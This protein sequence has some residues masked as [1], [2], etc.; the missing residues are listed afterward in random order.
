MVKT[1]VDKEHVVVTLGWGLGQGMV[2]VDTTIEGGRVVSSALDETK[3]LCPVTSNV[4]VKV[5]KV[6]HEDIVWGKGTLARKRQ[7][8]PGDADRTCPF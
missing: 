5:G 2:D 1:V 3:A 8:K 4:L 6:L 7:V